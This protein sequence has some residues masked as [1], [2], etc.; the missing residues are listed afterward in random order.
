[1][2]SRRS[3]SRRASTNGVLLPGDYEWQLTNH[4]VPFFKDDRL[5]QITVPVVDDYRQRKERAGKL[6]GASI[7]ETI[8]RLGQVLELAVER[9]LIAR[10][11]AKVGGK[12]RKAKTTTPRRTYL[13]RAEQ[14]DDS[15]DRGGLTRDGTCSVAQEDAERKQE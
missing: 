8:T 10:N 4:L 13:D 11:P 14:I 7:N 9:E 12:R 3:G 15:A 6:S 1:M 5:S 2:S